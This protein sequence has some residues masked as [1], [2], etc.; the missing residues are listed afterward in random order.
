MIETERGFPSEGRKV[1]AVRPDHLILAASKQLALC[2]AVAEAFNV[3]WFVKEL[4]ASAVTER[5]NL[6]SEGHQDHEWC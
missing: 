1:N 2:Q 6:L 3:L 4:P 5:A